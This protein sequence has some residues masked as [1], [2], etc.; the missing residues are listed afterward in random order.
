MLAIDRRPSAGL[1]S[2]APQ[3]QGIAV[4]IITHITRTSSQRAKGQGTP[5]IIIASSPSCGVCQ[6][7][8][9]MLSVGRGDSQHQP[10]D[11]QAVPWCP[12]GWRAAH[13]TATAIEM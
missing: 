6:L 5:L 8:G 7:G 2:T 3:Y 13:D 12:G 4:D 1:V 11:A 9:A 10:P